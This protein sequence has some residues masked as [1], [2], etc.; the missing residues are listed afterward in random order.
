[1]KQFLTMALTLLVAVAMQGQTIS[2]TAAEWATA[3][4]LQNGAAVTDY[5]KDGVTV[6]FAQGTGT[7][8]PSYNAQYSAVAAVSGNTMT[9]AIPEGK[10]LNQAVFTMYNA[11]MATNLT[12]AAWSGGSA[13]KQSTEVT[14]TGTEESLNVTFSAMEGFVAF[15]VT[16]SEPPVYPELSYNDTT[17]LNIPAYITKWQ[18]D[19][20][21]DEWP[22]GYVDSVR[23]NI[24]DKS[25]FAWKIAEEEFD[26]IEMSTDYLHLNGG[27]TLTI[28]APYKMKK[29]VLTLRGTHSAISWVNYVTCSS[30]EMTVDPEDTHYKRTVIWTGS[31]AELTFYTGARSPELTEIT[32]ISDTTDNKVNVTFYD[33]LGQVIKTEPVIIGGSATA[34]TLDDECFAGWDKDFTNVQGDLEVNPIKRDL[35]FFTIDEWKE[36][37]GTL[38]IPQATKGDYTIYSEYYEGG[39]IGEDPIVIDGVRY[40]NRLLIYSGYQ[41]IKAAEPFNNLTFVCRYEGNAANL[42]AAT[43]SSGVVAQDGLYVHWKGYTDSLRWDLPDAS[44]QICAYRIECRQLTEYTV[45]F[46][47]IHGEEIKRETVTRGGNATAPADMTET[48]YTFT[49]WD[50]SFTNLGGDNPFIEVHPVYEEVAGYVTVTF[51]DI[52]GNLIQRRRVAISGTVSAPQ[53]PDVPFMLF[54]GW[55]HDLTNI[56]DDV[57]IKAVY[58]IDWNNPD[59]LTLEQWRAASKQEGEFYAVKGISTYIMASHIDEDGTLSFYLNDS[60]YANKAALP[61][62]HS[63]G[64]NG[65]PFFHTA[66]IQNGDTLVVYGQYGKRRINGNEYW[67]LKDGYLLYQKNGTNRENMVYLTMPDAQAV[68]DFNGDGKKQVANLTIKSYD[69]DEQ[70]PGCDCRHTNIDLTIASTTSLAEGFMPQD[71]IV[72]YTFENLAQL[73]Y[74]PDTRIL[75]IED[76]NRDGKPEFATATQLWMSQNDAYSLELGAFAITNMDLN[77]DGRLDYLLLKNNTPSPYGQ[78]AYQAADGS[79]SIEAMKFVSSTPSQAGARK[80]QS[81][82]NRFNLPMTAIDLNGDGLMDLVNENSGMLYI[83]KGNGQWEWKSMGAHVILTDLNND[84]LTDFVLPSEA[85]TIAI[86][87]PTTQDYVTTALQSTGMVDDVVYCRDF[88][89]D[90]DI[91]LLVT[92]SAFYNSNVS[93]TCYFINDG[94]GQ[95]TKQNEQNY[96]TDNPLWFSTCQDVDGDGYYDLLAIRG[97]LVL[98]PPCKTCGDT[99]TANYA[100]MPEVVWLR[101]SVNNTFAAPQKLYEPE[102]PSGWSSNLTVWLQNNGSVLRYPRNS[103]RLHLNAEDLDGNG[104]TRVWYTYDYTDIALANGTT[105]LYPVPAVAANERPTAPAQPTVQ[106]NDGLLTVTWGNGSDSHTAQADLTYA[107][108]IGTS[109]GTNDILA[110]HAKADGNRRNCLD[111]N[112]GRAHSYTIDLRSYAPSDIY[113]AVQAID[114]QHAGSVWSEEATVAHTAVPVAISLS[115]SQISLNETV[116]VHYTAI[117]EGYTHSWR[118]EDGELVKDSTYLVLRFPTGGYKTITHIV[119]MPDGAKDSAS[120]VLSVTPAAVDS[121]I[122]LTDVQKNILRYPFADYTYDGLLDGLN[123]VV[124]EGDNTELFKQ[125]LGMWNSGL[126]AN[127]ESTI[128]EYVRWYDWNRDGHV[129]LLYHI[130]SRS[131]QSYAHL[132]HD[133][134]ALALT[135]KEYDNERLPYFL[136]YSYTNYTTYNYFSLKSDMQHVGFEEC[137]LNTTAPNEKDIETKI[138]H[139]NDDGTIGNEDFTIIGDA[140]QFNQLMRNGSEYIFVKDFDHDGFADIA[141]IGAMNTTYASYDE[142]PVFYNKGNGVYEQ[143]NIPYPESLPRYGDTYLEDLNGDGFQDLIVAHSNY[144]NMNTEDSYT[145]VL[146]NNN[147][148]SFTKQILPNSTAPYEYKCVF[149]D[150]DNNGYLDVVAPLMTEETNVYN[151]YVWYMNADGLFS[152]GVLIPE[153]K[154]ADGVKDIYL[155]Q[156]AHYLYAGEEEL[157]PVIAVADER[158]AAPTNIQ[159]TMTEIGLLLTW[160]AAVDDHTPAVLMRYN[161]SVKAEGATTYLFSPQNGGNEDAAYLPGFNYINA[162][163]FFIPTSVLNNGNYEI[164]LQAVDNQNKMSVFSETLVYNVVRNPIEAPATTCAWNYTSISYQGADETGTPVWDFGGGVVYNGSG[165]GPYTV[166]WQSGGE[167]V[168]ALT[169]GDTIYRDTIHVSDPYELPIYPPQDLYEDVPFTV[170]LPEGVTCVWKARLNDDTEWHPVD[171]TGILLDASYILIYDR[172][173][174]V[175]GA[176]IT[177]YLLPNESSLCN[178]KLELRF[179]F[180]TPDGCTGIYEYVVTVRPQTNIPTLT[181]VTTDA[182]G[183]NAISWTNVDAFNSINVYKEG[184]SLNDFQFIGSA[185]A[186]AGAF[187][188]ANSDATQKAERYRITGISANGTESPASTIHKT[189]HLTINRGVMDG[190]FNLIWNAYEGASI[191]SYNILRGA[192]PTSLAEIATVAASNTSYTDQ[193][194]VD[195]QPYYAVEYVLSAAANAPAANANRAPAA[196]LSGRSNVVD[197][198]NLTPQPPQPQNGITVRLYPNEW[199]TVYLYAWTG[200]GETQPCGAWPGT[201]VSKDA[202]GWWTYTFDQRIQEVNIIWHNGAGYQ[203]YDITSVAASTCYQ[204]GEFTGM[205]NANIIDCNT[206]IENTE[207]IEDIRTDASSAPRK[208]MIGNI[209]YILRGDKIYTLQGQEIK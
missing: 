85:L 150:V 66:Q 148:Q 177:A 103:Y 62:L 5:T 141:G 51:V 65:T 168:I 108:R 205:Y 109:S 169:L 33:F 199:N 104:T 92:F 144:W 124:Y 67:G 106:Y 102:F 26:K 60:A 111:G 151:I 35:L 190:T 84:G 50:T 27:S 77:N 15:S 41:Y 79:F 31:T 76:V 139:F 198:N 38:R 12:N 126:L 43:W 97:N 24:D 59:I 17:V 57:T 95:F 28:S 29:V 8:A 140:N 101:G 179:E 42:A 105:E 137:V 155:S 178:D 158:P 25:V 193:A 161:L 204:I 9:I 154:F 63:L 160:D 90:G 58:T 207:G 70:V 46:Y 98:T 206:P 135:A 174:K 125:A 45:I 195:A 143:H 145:F 16:F 52:D 202:E 40:D 78:I 149:T 7:S 146:W 96:G 203:T 121:A 133:P 118:Y 100:E 172:R 47:N 191:A 6:T 36:L 116:E 163:R 192:T 99:Y 37:Y 61:I 73:G 152:H 180:T 185:N 189:V 142:L 131:G 91:D 49:G 127:G 110:A 162:T 94:Q 55:S 74:S 115:R 134:A 72:R 82:G 119:T 11:T 34:P 13:A 117:P 170:S 88:D 64:L 167:K 114:A 4:S 136:G 159:A 197:R 1:M 123:T 39:G 171:K 89:K 75:N 186:S 20:P 153:V 196:A 208:V 23:F 176:T 128:P 184:S 19:N 166:Y 56:T 81:I 112:M 87:N 54:A 14:W 120:V 200:N 156:N 165:F 86:Y 113:V 80:A 187:T 157:Y 10:Q 130:S 194:P 147:N 69:V 129:D 122:A 71:T 183:H 68:Y 138:I 107:L 173:L 21:W 181:L 18:E 30:G 132:L 32:I 44:Y 93:Y 164:R 209:I 175:N 188:D 48:G 3:K 182:N 22:E 201:A 83:N 53:A 2:F